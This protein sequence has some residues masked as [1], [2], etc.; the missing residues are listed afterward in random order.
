MSSFRIRPHIRQTM[1]QDMATVQETLAGRLRRPEA[2]CDVKDF[3]GYL[4]LH[5]PDQD[6]HFWSPQLT[7]SLEESDD[8]QTIIQG[9]YGPNTNVWSLFLYGY[10][11]VGTLGLFAAV[12]GFSQ[13]L[14][15]KQPWGLW[16]LGALLAVAAGLYLV[17]QFGQKLGARQTFLL[18][19]E[20]EAAVGGPVE[21]D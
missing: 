6:Q 3:H 5:I 12:L 2:R 16:I 4:S 19:Q 17:A 13:W 14:I 15:G 18:H 1:D 9:V 11:M 10:L 20:F 21:I 8:G 7:L